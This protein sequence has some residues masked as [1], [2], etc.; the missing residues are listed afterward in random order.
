MATTTSKKRNLKYLNRDF[1]SFKRDFIEH[2]KVYFPDTVQ[3]F[4]E[5][6][7][8]MMFTEMASFIGDNLSFYLD[9][10]FNESFLETA[11]ERKNVFKHAKQL[12]FKAFGKTAAT[13]VVDAFLKVPAIRSG[14]KIIPDM[15]F[16]GKIKKGA[17]LKSTAGETYETLEDVDFST[18]RSNDSR[19]VQVGDRDPVTKAPTTFVLKKI[20][21]DVAAGETK[22]TTV[23][24]GGYEAFKKVTL[25]DEDVLEVTQIDDAEGNRWYEVEFLAQDTVF[26]GLANTGED[27]DDVPFVLKLRSV[28]YRFITEFDVDANRMS[29]IFG[30]GDAQTFDGDLIPDLGD[31]S[32]PLFGKDHF[33][34]FALDPQNF[35]KTS[36]LGLTPVNTTLTI[37]YR[38]GGG[39]ATNA[40]TGEIQ[41]VVEST[42]EV[43][44]TSL[45]SAT[46]K[47]VGNSFS[48]KNPRPVQGGKDESTLEEIRQLISANFA[49]QSRMV[50]AQDFVMRALSMPSKFGSVFR[51]NARAS[52]FNKNAVELIVLSRDSNGYVTVAPIDLKNNLKR[53]LSRF[54]M[55][56]DAIEILDGEVINIGINFSILTNPDYNKAEVLANCIEALQEFFDIETWQMNQP[57]NL[58]DVHRVIS[59]IPGVLSLVNFQIINR[60]G[61]FDSRSY[62]HKVHNIRQKTQNGIVYAEE[63]AIFEV[64]YPNKDI[65]GTAK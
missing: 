64:K 28:P 40:G 6:S 21:V 4:N 31:L 59:D 9:K 24:I 11:R 60:V 53:Y 52:R 49:T 44:D 38:I 18:V 34:D 1:E 56:T 12:G 2:L 50:S 30:S 62:S 32:L 17:K 25:G 54:R 27:S 5:S 41:T 36:T 29:V 46:I 63:N 14:Q 20:D 48:V 8:G 22:T 39:A 33:T 3:D 23:T 57:I 58:T 13:G 7:V 42:F 19:Y 45:S 51:A 15:R 55:L 16:A 61:T 65:I 26:D 47:D 37:K 10:R 35:L 43:G